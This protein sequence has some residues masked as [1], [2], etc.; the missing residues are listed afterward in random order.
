MGDILD[1]SEGYRRREIPPRGMLVRE[2]ASRTT[3]GRRLPAGL[4]STA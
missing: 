2:Y 3:P 4:F 1:L